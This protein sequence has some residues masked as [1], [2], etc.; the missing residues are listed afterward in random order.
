MRS[1][2]LIIAIRTKERERERERERKKDRKGKKDRVM[3]E[4]DTVCSDA[5]LDIY[6]D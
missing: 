1:Q 2:Y 3:C 6:L 5:V 4:L